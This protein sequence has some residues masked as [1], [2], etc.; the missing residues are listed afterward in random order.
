MEIVLISLFFIFLFTPVFLDIYSRRNIDVPHDYH[1][2][3]T[4]ICEI[5][6]NWKT[7]LTI[8]AISSDRKNVVFEEYPDEICRL[9]ATCENESLKQR[10]IQDM[11]E[12]SEELK[13]LQ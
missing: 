7:K 10:K 8:K 5:R 11:V 2:G 13:K 9:N 4:I 6:E 12:F 3:D 1:I